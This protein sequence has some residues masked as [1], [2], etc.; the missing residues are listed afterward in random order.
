MVAKAFRKI[1][2]G[3]VVCA[4]AVPAHAAVCVGGSLNSY[5]ALGASGCTVGAL[6]FSDFVVDTFPG[7]TATQ[8]APGTLSIAPIAGGF[9]LSSSTGLATDAGNL[10]GFRL[11]FD[12][13]APAL[14]G[15][16]VGFGANRSVSGDGALTAL[17]DAGTSGNAIALVVDGFADTPASFASSAVGS[18]AAFLELGI[19]AGTFGF[20]SLGP[21][22]ASLT[23][24]VGNIAPVPEP[25]IAMLTLAG[26]IAL[27]A[28]RRRSLAA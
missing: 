20:A 11:L 27:F 3:V 18:Y 22:L 5:L 14:I 8:I 26:L 10:I 21:E 13:Q 16:T 15:G 9:S 1:L 23:F 28:R 24:A 7:P 17:L 19:D 6:T 25:E 12:V 2:C 4:A